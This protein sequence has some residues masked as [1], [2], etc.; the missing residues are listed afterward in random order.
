MKKSLLRLLCPALLL[1]LLLTGCTPASTNPETD[2]ATDSSAAPDSAAITTD[3]VTTEEPEVVLQVDASYCIA[4][5]ADAD[6]LTQSAANLLAGTI[7][8]RVALDLPVVSEADNAS[9]HVISLTIG[10]T[11]EARSYHVAMTAEGLTV[12][13]SDSTTLYF[14]VEAIL[15]TWLTPEFGLSAEGALTLPESRVVELTGLETRLSTSIKILTQNVRAYNDAD[16]NTIPNRSVRFGQL[17]EEYVPDVFGVQEYTKGWDIWLQ[18]YLEEANEKGTLPEYAFLGCSREGWDKN[19]ESSHIV[20]RTDRFELVETNTFWLSPYPDTPS[21]LDA[22]L[23]KRICTW[24]LLK[25]LKT[26]QTILV[27]NTHLDHSTDE[28]RAA[29]LEILLNTITELV[30]DYPLYLTGDFNCY[31]GS[32]PYKMATELLEDAHQSAWVDLSTEHRTFHDYR[33]FGGG[34]I[35]FIFHNDKS[36]PISYQILSKGYDGY[37]SDHYGVLAEFI[38]E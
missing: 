16:G 3:S 5:P 20:Y 29:Q 31:V 36:S 8:D 9:A 34:E 32:E 17:L 7:L 18:R 33:E 35:D 25:D 28:V 38:L 14:A 4:I 12:D 19:G 26:G 10:G 6:E 11:E 2:A 37:V 1:S 21:K 30:G 27:A 24:A 13:A 22:S 23:N 15:Q